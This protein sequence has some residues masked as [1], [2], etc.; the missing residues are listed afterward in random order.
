MR[1]DK[2]VEA[3][4]GSSLFRAVISTL[5]SLPNGRRLKIALDRDNPA[6]A[7]SRDFGDRLFCPIHNSGSA[8]AASYE[9][10][11]LPM[12]EQDKTDFVRCLPLAPG[13]PWRVKVPV[14]GVDHDVLG[15]YSTEKGGTGERFADGRRTLA[16]QRRR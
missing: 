12:A 9:W 11:P 8:V 14:L 2:N 7:S 6:P 15:L 4:K 3:T 13:G 16:E 5:A 1:Q 10:S